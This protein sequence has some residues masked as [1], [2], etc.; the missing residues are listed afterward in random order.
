MPSPTLDETKG[1][2]VKRKINMIEIKERE[3]LR[4]RNVLRRLQDRVA[5][6]WINRREIIMLIL[7]NS[8]L[9]RYNICI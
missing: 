2:L 5:D 8:I 3:K 4:E 6:A 7:Q 9:L 1:K